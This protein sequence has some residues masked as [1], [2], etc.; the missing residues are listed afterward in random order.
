MEYNFKRISIGLVV[1]LL[2]LMSGLVS[3]ATTGK[4]AGIVKD[5]ETGDPL[6]GAN[7]IIQGTNRGAATGADGKFVIINVPPGTY[8]LRIQMIGYSPV[9]ITE[10]QVF[11]DRVRQIE[12]ELGMTVLEGEE[13]TIVAGRE[14]I[15]IDRT[16]TASY[17]SE[18]EISE[19][20]VSTLAE[21]VQLQAG[22]VTD[23]GGGLHFRGGRSREVA[24]M[25]DGIPVTN[26][27]SQG[28]GSNVQLE[29]NFI[30]ELQ[31]ITGTFNAEYGS[32][33]SGVINVVTKVPDQ[34]YSGNIE[35]LAGGFYAPNSKGFIGLDSYDPM[36]NRELKWSVSGPIPFPKSLGQLGFYVNGRVVDN[37][38]WLNG[39][40]RFRPEDG[41][42]I[43]VFREWYR[44][45]YDPRD[46]LIIPIPDS[47]H[48]GNSEITP[49]NWTESYSIN[50][51]LVYQPFP[52]LTASYNLFVSGS[53][54]K[55]YNHSWRYVPEALPFRYNN[56]MTHMLVLTHTPRNNIFYN[57]R[58]SFQQNHYKA[59]TFED[60]NDPRYQ[61]ASINAWDP[62][63]VTGYDYGGIYSWDRRWNDRNLHLMN[64]DLTWQINQVFE[65]K[66]GF[67]FKSH[68]LHYK[69][70]PLRPREGY[71][72]MQ[73]PYT[74]NEI[75]G[76]EL[77]YEY[78]MEQ[79]RDFEYGTIRLREAHPDSTDDHLIYVD[80]NRAPVEGSAF[81]QTKLNMG[82]IILNAGV[83]FD[84]LDPEDRYAP[85]YS[86]VFPEAVGADTF[87]TEA[88]EKYQVSPRLGLSFPISD[89]GALR[90]SYGHFFQAPSL[91]K[92]Y[93]N[94]VLEHYNKF[95]IMNSTIG[96]PNLNAEKTVQYEIGL[97][98]ELVPGLS[99]ELT[100]Y[101]K[102]IRDL[103]G[104]EILTLSDATTFY[105]YVNKEYGSSSGVTFALNYTTPSG[106]I[107]AGVDYTYMTAK[108]TASS[109]EAVRD[110]AILSG[111]SRG[112]YTLG[113]RRI[114]FL[115]WDQ[116]HSL[117]ASFSIRPAEGW[118]A[119]LTGQLGSG[120]PYSPATLDPNIEVPGHWWDNAG[121][122]PFRWNV[123]FKLNKS[124]QVA[125]AKLAV[126]M[127]VYNIFNQ[128][129][130]N[131]VRP[132]T[133]RAG[134]D[135]YLPE[136]ARKRYWRL[137]T[138][139]AFTREE[140][141]YNP[142]H[143]SRPRLIQFGLSVGL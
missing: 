84:Y 19:L 60:P 77:P 98:Q 68:D 85:S 107:N 45:T 36:T 117:N 100:V 47:M 15:E 93:Q 118:Y 16:N 123:D 96:N 33:Q 99:T 92:M 34:N 86:D 83:R 55:V 116:T 103:L 69:N 128:L 25:I 44:A 106:K 28:G 129:N 101:Y 112:A 35:V 109:A 41:W 27:F 50:T 122:K 51:K 23:A 17:V 61:N 140:A 22:V 39:E 21:V 57:L 74:R 5:S 114:Q 42:E 124:F 56:G 52:A 131:Y 64:G 135:A 113:S 132:I 94:P 65:V 143:Y 97:Q 88:S 70:A 29:N 53:E 75:R 91:E 3:A 63:A 72:I 12:A 10:V 48:T 62:G 90:L 49:I 59:Y 82:E 31:V 130:E 120:L 110:V 119:S 1:L 43:E 11:T 137:E 73:F 133:G 58:Y 40:R 8:T 24:Y 38:G 95:S 76:L 54:G 102:D 104:L 32:A 89:R 87:Y 6:P 108:G 26:N 30:K 66:T 20:P 136:I 115:D 125:G 126:F 81:A 2:C 71:E 7:V 37:D 78:F 46:P 4:I 138:V 105:R 13:V 79:T 14:P 139:G 142:T 141:D 18:D 67:E 121:R 127:N 111:K 9:N 80:Y 134:P